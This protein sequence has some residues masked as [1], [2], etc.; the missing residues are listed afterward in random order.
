MNVQQQRTSGALVDRPFGVGEFDA[1]LAAFKV[2]RDRRVRPKANVFVAA[3]AATTT[4]TAATATITTTKTTP[5][6]AV[7]ST[8][9]NAMTST[10]TAPPPST[11]REERLR[12]FLLSKLD[13]DES[14]VDRV[15]TE[16]NK[17]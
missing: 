4:T 10:K 15:C 1:K 14:L 17:L 7:K 12:T 8:T 13:N 16:F 2:V 6:V 3:T 5:V 9:T 11:T